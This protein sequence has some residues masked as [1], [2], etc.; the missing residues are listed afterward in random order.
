MTSF[1]LNKISSLKKSIFLYRI[2]FDK[3]LK[4]LLIL[5]NSLELMFLLPDNMSNIIEIN[6]ELSEKGILLI[7]AS[8]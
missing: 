4:V 7:L 1:P 5:S 3:I 6:L 8:V 2:K